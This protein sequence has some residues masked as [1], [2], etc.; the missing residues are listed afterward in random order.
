MHET[1]VSR[2]G[3]SLAAL[4]YLYTQTRTRKLSNTLRSI[5]ERTERKTGEKF[6]VTTC[7]WLRF[8]FD[9]PYRYVHHCGQYFFARLYPC[10]ACIAP[11][12]SRSRGGL[13]GLT[14]SK[15]DKP[16]KGDKLQ[17]EYKLSQVQ[18]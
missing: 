1:D 4:T 16:G 8:S 9:L 17:V 14:S 7:L 6:P 3:H 2:S 13:H 10:V 5:D 12:T 15:S 18:S 11:H